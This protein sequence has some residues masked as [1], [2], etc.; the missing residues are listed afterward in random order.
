MNTNA[1]F[2]YFN[3]FTTIC[4]DGSVKINEA[5][6]KLSESQN[7]GSCLE[8]GLKKIACPS[9][10]KY[11]CAIRSSR[12]SKP[13]AI[14]DTIKFGCET[15]DT[16]NNIAGVNCCTEDKCNCNNGPIGSEDAL[17]LSYYFKRM[18]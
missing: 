15:E 6:I 7:I 3:K 2:T 17:F 11:L 14:G 18:V 10:G 1:A 12:P 9:T 16:C 5:N 4:F 8:L 13:I